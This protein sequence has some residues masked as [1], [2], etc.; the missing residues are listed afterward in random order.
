[1]IGLDTNVLVR[2]LTQDDDKQWKQ[3][4]EIIESG[5]QCFICNVVLCEVIWVLRE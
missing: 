2:Y 4:V 3:A 1:V 5:E